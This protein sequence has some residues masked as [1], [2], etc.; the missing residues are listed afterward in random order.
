VLRKVLIIQ[1]F[2]SSLKH[3]TIRDVF[4]LA[5]AANMIKFSNYSYEPS[6][7]TRA[8]TGK[9]DIH[10]F[11]VGQLI[12]EKLTEMLSDIEVINKKVKKTVPRQT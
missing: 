6:L 2:I 5:F 7:A 11:P 12:I 3:E 4:R 10:D 9:E 1:D 8:S